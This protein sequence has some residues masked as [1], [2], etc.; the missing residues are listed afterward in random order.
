MFTSR[1]AGRH[2]EVQGQQAG[3]GTV[4]SGCQLR[5]GQRW[6][7]EDR[8][9]VVASGRM[10]TAAYQSRA[11]PPL[12]G[13]ALRLAPKLVFAT[14]KARWKLLCPRSQRE[15][16]QVLHTDL[17]CPGQNFLQRSWCSRISLSSGDRPRGDQDT[18]G[19]G[20]ALST[21]SP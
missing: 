19:V 1:Q 15:S 4:G 3:E 21:R 20:E 18:L 7:G 8:D 11:H 5:S 16:G 10:Y 9:R 14:L 13:G 6:Q 12:V 2:V 17:C